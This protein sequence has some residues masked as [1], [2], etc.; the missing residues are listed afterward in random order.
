MK[1]IITY[2]KDETKK[3][4]QEIA[5]SSNVPRIICL[6]GDLGSGKTTFSKGFGTALG[7]DEDKIKSPTYTFVRSYQLNSGFFHHF[8]F[9]RIDKP[10]ELLIQEIKEIF[11]Q[12]NAII[13]IE[14]PERIKDLLPEKRLNIYFTYQDLN[15]RK[16]SYHYD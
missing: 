10:D 6:Y 7:L 3:F 1:T 2:S 16:I 8:D 11:Q 5:K 14:W 15:S 4:A 12:Q 9:Y 13:V